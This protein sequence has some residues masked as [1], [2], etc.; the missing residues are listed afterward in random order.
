MEDRI[1]SYRILV[2]RH[3]VK[4]PLGNYGVD[5]KLIL[6]LVFKTFDGGRGHELDRSGLG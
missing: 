2:E 1:C 4:M 6:K 5:G 3:I